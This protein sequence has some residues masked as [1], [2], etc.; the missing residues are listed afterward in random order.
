MLDLAVSVGTPT[1]AIVLARPED[2]RV[3]ATVERWLSAHAEASAF[4]RVASNVLRRS[5]RD[6]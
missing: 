4:E 2:A 3:Q 1:C 5:A 6:S